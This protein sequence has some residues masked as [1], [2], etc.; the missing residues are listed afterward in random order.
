MLAK[1]RA[2]FVAAYNCGFTFI[3]FNSGNI[4]NE[5]QESFVKYI[6]LKEI[7]CSVKVENTQGGHEEY[8]NIMILLLFLF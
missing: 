7:L 5:T 6:T 3:I 2:G 8:I 1:C 4:Q